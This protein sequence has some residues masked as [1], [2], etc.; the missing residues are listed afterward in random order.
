MN[1]YDSN[2]I[3]DLASKKGFEKTN[4]FEETDCYVLNTCHI[5]EKSTEKVY[6]DIGRLKKNFLNKK[7]PYVLVT[8]CV[9]QAE[10]EVMLK[11]EPYIDA[12]VGP[13]SYQELSQ[14]FSSFEKRKKNNFTD[15]DV[16]K[17]FDTLNKIKNSISKVSSFVTIQE[18]CDKFCSFCVVPYTTGQE[19]SRN[20]KDIIRE[21]KELVKNGVRE[22]TLLG[23]NVNAY[24]FT[25]NKKKSRLSD[26]IFELDEIRNLKRVR[27]TT[28]HPNDMTKDLIDCYKYSKKLM[29]FLHLPVQSGSNIILKKMNRRH[30]REEYLDVIQN[31]MEVNPKMSFSSDFIVGYPEETSRD[32]DETISLI[33]EVKF[34]NS[35]S[36][37]FS[38][39]PGTPAAKMKIL[40]KKIQQKRLI[41]LQDLLEKIK[42][43]KNKNEVGKINEVL[44]ENKMKNQ[45]NYFSRNKSSTP[46]IIEEASE[47]DVGKLVNV[48]IKKYNRNSLFG[49]VIRSNKVGEAA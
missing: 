49:T 14:I 41:I 40:N 10:N 20:P 32:F 5:R 23:Q 12:V 13:Q 9:A 8:G 4:N 15:F 2:R 16:V 7:K 21:A 6:S 37:I 46:V 19:F 11:R 31:L 36:F 24:N 22:I 30:T 25:E 28:S 44:V 27:Y 45:N 47:T 18:G 34:I 33:N 42:N 26:L 39:R 43:Y 29:P 48:K 38:P 1:E 35:Y 17:K 3:Y